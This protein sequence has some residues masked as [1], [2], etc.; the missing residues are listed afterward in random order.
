ME[1]ERMKRYRQEDSREIFTE[2]LVA[3]FAVVGGGLAGVCAAVTAARQGVRTVLVQDRPVLGGNASSEVR[4]WALGATSH[5]GNNNR[6]SR[7]GGVMDE[8][9]V[10]N[11]YRNPEG[12]PH[13]FDAVLLDLVMA[14]QHITLLLDTVVYALETDEARQIEKVSAFCGQNETAYMIS[15]PLFC[16]ASGDGI[17]GYLSGASYRV[18]AE[19]ADE[20]DEPF[21][22]D[23]AYGGLLGHSMYFYSRDTGKPVQFVAPD[24][25]LK[26]ITDIPRYRNFRAGDTGC[27]LWW[28]EYGG[29]LDTV[30]DTRQIKQE[31]QR[32]IFGVWDY[33]KNSGE[34]PE[35]ENLTLEWVGNVPGKRESRRFEGDYMLHQRD[36]IEQRE[37]ADAVAYGGW[38]IDLHPGDGVYSRLDGCTQWHSKGV[39]QIP[40]RTLYSRD[41]PNLFLAGRVISA[42]HVAFGSTRV[43][44]TAGH[45]A[46]AV[47][48]AA[49]QC[50]ERGLVPRGLTDRDEMRELQ[51]NLLAIGQ[52]IPGVELDHPQDLAKR[53]D[54]SASSSFSM[55]ELPAGE[56][57]VA[58]DAKRGMLLPFAQGRLPEITLFF[59]VEDS[60]ELEVQLRTA[61][62]VG[63]YTPDTVL[64]TR[65]LTLGAGQAV[66]VSLQFESEL[67]QDQYAFI[68][69]METEGVDVLLSDL[70]VSGVLSV[71]QEG[72]R[73]VSKA[74]VQEPPEGIGVERVEFWLPQRRPG[75]KNFAVKCASPSSL[76]GAPQVLSAPQRP[77]TSPNAWVADP[78]DACP[79][80]SLEWREPVRLK[81][82]VLFF[83]TDFDHPM[84]TVQMG[85]PEREIPFCVKDFDLLDDEGNVIYEARNNHRTRYEAVFKKIV[86]TKK[87]TLRI[88]A[89]HGAP[90]AVFKV[91]CFGEK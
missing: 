60:C 25:A 72:N 16:D 43:M 51:R 30:Y 53:A 8:I 24:F 21:A 39:Y 44:A 18:G 4:L 79:Q 68:C 64:E 1:K 77:T 89:T 61:K 59:N 26:D 57:A 5:L 6:W 85:H 48:M 81:K 31:L 29:R 78:S 14:E 7:E 38:A 11:L 87:I 52:Y 36:V 49:F 20:F 86:E 35:A 50:L 70:R 40:Y 56:E 58:L 74:N 37:H 66:R 12:N 62:K 67:A 46:Q 41:V 32:V 80:L 76:F 15:A 34:F 63:N 28:L 22:P 45:T 27:Q 54:V 88:P 23:A 13:L 75:G 83:D 10:E 91:Q 65:V 19:A 69:L 9:L 90:A 47:G 3:D 42:T 2:E 17:L 82:A 73:R 55:L 84:E 33:I 71:A